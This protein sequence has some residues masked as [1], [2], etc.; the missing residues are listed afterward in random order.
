MKFKKIEKILDHLYEGVHIVNKNM[1]IVYWNKSA[2]DISG[3]KFSEITGNLCSN[4]ILEHMDIK[5]NSL[6]TFG[7]PMMKVISDGKVRETEL[8]IHHKGGHRVPVS[9]KSLPFKDDHGEI[10]GAIEIFSENSDRKNI[11]KRVRELEELALI[12]ELTHLPNR[13]CLENTI[14][15]KL[16]EYQLNRVKFGLIFI[17]IDH[18][19]KFND[20]YGHDIG[21]LVL[22]VVSETFLNNLRGN[23]II[24]RWGGEEFVGLF[25]LADEKDLESIGEKLRILVERTYIE[26]EGKKL[27]ITIS[28][29]ATL[30]NSYDS[31]ETIIKR[32]D[33]LLYK[34]KRKGR[35]LVNIG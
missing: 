21:D 8:F 4:N 29:G 32:A 22:K 16:N 5:G 1:E 17:D 6:C 31:P 19:K 27:N 30:I 3:Y 12:D 25:F 28:L 26:V 33:N 11:L 23:D 20:N 2:E 9:M 7:C 13:R 24:G 15:L 35:N 34:S 14:G 18:F 10:I